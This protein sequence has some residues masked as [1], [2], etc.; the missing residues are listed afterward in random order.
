[1]VERLIMVKT[2]GDCP[3]KQWREKAWRCRQSGNIVGTQIELM[4]RIPDNCPLMPKDQ[5]GG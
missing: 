3:L 1:M 4:D 2:C 5:G